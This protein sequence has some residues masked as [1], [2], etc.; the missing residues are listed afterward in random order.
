MNGHAA[1]ARRL[2][3]HTMSQQLLLLALVAA[4]VRSG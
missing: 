3:L 2:W 4:L 1:L